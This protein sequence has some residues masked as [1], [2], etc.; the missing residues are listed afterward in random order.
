MKTYEGNV[1]CISDVLHRERLL[2]LIDV[3]PLETILEREDALPS[4]SRTFGI[5]HRLQF[6]QLYPTPD[7]PVL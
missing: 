7:E 6:P 1:V 5:H 3:S 4:V 2:Q